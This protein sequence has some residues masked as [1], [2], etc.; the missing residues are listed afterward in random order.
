MGH[1]HLMYRV[2]ERLCESLDWITSFVEKQVLKRG[3][4]LWKQ[5]ETE[6]PEE[7]LEA[8]R[9]RSKDKREAL[10]RLKA[11]LMK[12]MRHGEYEARELISQL[13]RASMQARK[14]FSLLT[15]PRF[16]LVSAPHQMG[17]ALF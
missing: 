17:N 6:P 16:A 11:V 7:F 3:E 14:P 2:I 9:V 12:F 13:H 8:K 4:S 1:R 15:R 5:D 10:S